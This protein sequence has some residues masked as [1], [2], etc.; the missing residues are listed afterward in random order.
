MGKKVITAILKPIGQLVGS[1]GIGSLGSFLLDMSARIGDFFTSLNENFS[2]DGITGVL[3][4]IVSGISNAIKTAFNS[5]GDF[6]KIF[7]SVGE[8][9]CNV[10]SKIWNAV[11]KV[12]DGLQIMFPFLIFLQGLLA[13]EYL[14]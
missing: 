10:A 8:S 13:E 14:F 5:I 2:T 1:E 7:S 9:I 3:S 4:N 11:T 12:L 6:G